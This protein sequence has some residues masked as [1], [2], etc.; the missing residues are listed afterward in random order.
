MNSSLECEPKA[1]TIGKCY[2][3]YLCTR[4][5][6]TFEQ[7]N[8][9]ISFETFTQLHQQTQ[10]LCVS[11]TLMLS[12]LREIRVAFLSLFLFSAPNLCENIYLL[13]CCCRCR[14]C[15]Y[16]FS[17]FPHSKSFH[18]IYFIYFLFFTHQIW[19][20]WCRLSYKLNS[21]LLLLSEIISAFCI[22]QRRYLLISVGGKQTMKNVF[23]FSHRTIYH[24][25]SFTKEKKN[26]TWNSDSVEWEVKYFI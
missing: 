15:C 20:K 18:S 6:C 2:E 22:Q 21:D 4:F 13:C 14:R 16:C 8:P 17:S 9:T 25:Q 7:F 11:A 19:R 10:L 5:E 3:K 26:W 1:N 24:F 12:L 23:V